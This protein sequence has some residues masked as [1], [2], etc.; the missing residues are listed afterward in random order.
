[1]LIAGLAL[2]TLSACTANNKIE[3]KELVTMKRDSV[4]VSDLYK[5]IQVFP[6][7]PSAVLVQNLTLDKILN[8][9]F[10]KEVD[11]KS[12]A[13]QVNALKSQYG[14]QFSSMLQQSGLTSDNL[15][16]YL[17]TGM[18][19]QSAI[20]ADIIKTQYTT[21]NMKKVWRNYHP[22]VTAYVVSETSK[23]KATKDL[24]AAKKDSAG[25]ENF[26]KMNSK[27]KITFSSSSTTVPAEV[28]QASFKL[29]NGE[30][31]SAIEASNSTSDSGAYYIVEMVKSSDKGAD[32]NKYKKEL[33]ESIKLEKTQDSSYRNDVI[34]KYLKKNNVEVKNKAFSAIF[35]QFYTSS[36]K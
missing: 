18:L 5:E 22:N 23:D 1:M 8:K 3:N 36:T 19:E 32:M 34:A 15:K 29:K 28:Q 11:D 16:D 35:S 26:E 30:F 31:S 2:I 14:A 27:S 9:N 33:Q 6:N 20:N 24:E 12:I 4:K 7:I 25:R 10:G 21:D 17:R 13:K